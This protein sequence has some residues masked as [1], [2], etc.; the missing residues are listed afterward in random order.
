M[1]QEHFFYFLKLMLS[2]FSVPWDLSQSTMRSAYE[3]IN[4]QAT[5]Q[6]VNEYLLKM[7]VLITSQRLK[8]SNQFNFC[9]INDFTVHPSLVYTRKRWSKILLNLQLL[10]PSNS[11]LIK[12]VCWELWLVFLTRQFHS[13]KVM[14]YCILYCVFLFFNIEILRI[15]SWLYFH[16]WLPHVQNPHSQKIC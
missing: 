15:K 13:I 1:I 5:Q 16:G 14:T 9:N 2:H 12:L 10:Q 6:F 8:I 7:I 3:N 11:F 4:E